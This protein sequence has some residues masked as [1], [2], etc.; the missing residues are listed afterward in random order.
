MLRVAVLGL[1]PAKDRRTKQVPIALGRD[2]AHLPCWELPHHGHDRHTLMV[3][4]FSLHICGG[5]CV[6]HVR[7]RGV[8]TEGSGESGPHPCLLLRALPLPP[9]A[10]R[11][12][13]YL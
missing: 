7:Q 11:P 5:I 13:A 8:Y 10:D 4:P 6:S 1:H 2:E 12:L 9:Q 3:S